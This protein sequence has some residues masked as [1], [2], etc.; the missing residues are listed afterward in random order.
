[1]FILAVAVALLVSPAAAVTIRHDVADASYTG[2]AGNADYQAVG[3]FSVTRTGG[4]FLGSGTLISSQWVL[5]AAHVVDTG[6]TNA[7]GNITALS[8]TDSLGGIHN[9]DSVVVHPLWDGGLQDGYDM[10]LVRLASPIAGISAAD[11]YNGSSEAG[12]TITMVGYG[13]TGTGSTG[14]TLAA[15]TRR[16]GMNVADGV[17]G[18]VVGSLNLAGWSANLIFSDFDEPGDTSESLM[19][20]NT[21][22]GLEGSTAPGD[23]GG[24]VFIDVSGSTYL[25]GVTSLGASIDGQTNSDYGD[26]FASTRVSQF[27][28]WIS[29]STGGEAGGGGGAAPE[30]ATLGF[31]AAAALALYATGRRR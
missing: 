28:D 27:L 11:L 25:A 22:L 20:G 26:I 16:A 30:P 14:D 10:A 7:S 6:A 4:S 15:G 24:G 23:S 12:S 19:G 8:F 17:G 21:P 1:V 29:S 31:G 18:G 5:T 13:R 9:F 2:L 3:R